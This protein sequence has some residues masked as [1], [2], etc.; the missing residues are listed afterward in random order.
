MP[1]YM[2]S[3]NILQR[4][5]NLT[6][7]ARNDALAEAIDWDITQ[8]MLAAEATCKST[9]QSPWS[10]AL[11]EVMNRLFILKQVLRKYLTRLDMSASIHIMLS[12]LTSPTLIPAEYPIILSMLRQARRDRP[13]AIK[14]G[15]QLRQSSQQEKIKALQMANPEKIPKK[16]EKVFLN[17]QA[18]KEMFQRVPS[19]RAILSGGIC[20]IKVPTNPNANLKA[21]SMVFKSIVKPSE[22]EKHILQQN[23]LHFAQARATPLAQ[24]ELTKIYSVSVVHHLL[25]IK[26]SRAQFDPRSLTKDI[27]GSA[28]LRMCQRTNPEMHPDISLDKFKQALKTW[29]V[30]TSTSP[31]GRHLSHQHAL[32]QP[33]GID[34]CIDPDAHHQAEEARNAS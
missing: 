8:S 33:H 17:T 34:P 22:V 19:A 26:F 2:E 3:H 16:V 5:D 28:I 20:M 18:S 12:K 4:L 7:G 14:Q 29:Q 24:N 11:H 30:G 13:E 31:S 21:A 23:Q 27:H 9:P 15:D 10:K 6:Q 25:H 1:K 32:F